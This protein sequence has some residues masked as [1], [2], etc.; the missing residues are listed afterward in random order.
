MKR[1]VFFLLGAWGIVLLASGGSMADLIRVDSVVVSA[2]SLK[3]AERAARLEA[4]KRALQMLGN[5]EIP[6]EVR[7]EILLR[8]KDFV[9]IR[10]VLNTKKVRGLYTPVFFCTVD[11]ADIDAIIARYRKPTLTA[12][13][14]PQINIAVVFRSLPA[15][16]AGEKAFFLDRVN[17]L[18]EEHFG[19]AGFR[20]GTS[21]SEM[22]GRLNQKDPQAVFHAFVRYST[23]VNYLLFG[24]MDLLD[25]DI[26]PEDHGRYI[27]GRVGL[28]LRFFC[29]SSNDQVSFSRDVYGIGE[30][31]SACIVNAMSNCAQAISDK[32]GSH[33]IIADWNRK[34]EEGFE[35]SLMFCGANGNRWITPLR[36][37]LRKRG[38]FISKSRGD[39]VTEIYRFHAYPGQFVFPAVDFEDLLLDLNGFEG[40]KSDVTL[41]GDRLYFVFGDSPECFDRGFDASEKTTVPV[42]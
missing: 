27:K 35:Y 36:R 5:R 4:L 37:A 14:R 3:E 17:N 24:A 18:L 7:D 2:P 28:T 32:L 19:K 11:S 22:I 26:R 21:P 23:E 30:N 33:R 1:A 38:E 10:R 20:I 16:F 12:L 29:V 42:K 31:E 8:S 6:A 40:V 25:D 39:N 13:K 41:V 9:T 15:R 34:L